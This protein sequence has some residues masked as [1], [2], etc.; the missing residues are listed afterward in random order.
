MSET[1]RNE[2]V[3][4][5]PNGVVPHP[6]DFIIRIDGVNQNGITSGYLRIR[7]ADGEVEAFGFDVTDAG[8]WAKLEEFNVPIAKLCKNYF[9]QSRKIAHARRELLNSVEASSRAID[10]LTGRRPASP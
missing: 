3:R 9:D 7:A 4:P 8:V 6:K 2:P 5:L 1:A 10:V